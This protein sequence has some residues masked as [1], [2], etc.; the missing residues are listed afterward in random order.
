MDILIPI[1][2]IA[3]LILLNGLF[4][5]AEFAIIGAPRSAIE[6]RA[7]DGDPTARRVRDIQNDPR[8]QDRYIATAQLGIT[9]ASLG[10]GMYGEHTLAVWIASWL[11]GAAWAKWLLAHGLASGVAILFLTYLH[12]VLGE[13]V[14]KTFALSHAEQTVL[15]V[16]TP[17]LVVKRLLLPLVV[18]LN[19]TGNGLLALM[20]V[21]REFTKSHYH[22]PEELE[23]IIRE[24]EAGGLIHPETGRLLRELFD[25]GELTASE[26]AVPRVRMV[27]LP[28]NA[29]TDTIAATVRRAPHARYP[30]Y[31]R[32][33]DHIIGFV[34]VKVL[35]RL[36]GS[37]GTLEAQDVAPVAF[38]PES[39]PLADVLSAMHAVRSQLAIVMDEHGGTEGMISTEDLSAEII[40]ATEESSGRTRFWSREPDGRY[41]VT[42]TLR[43]EELAEILAVNVRHESVDTVSGLV[44]DLLG[45]PPKVGDRV[46]WRSAQ[47]EVTSVAGRGVGECLVALDS[48]STAPPPGA[49]S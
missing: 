28:I 39:A 19:S 17:M 2:I 35:L 38:V 27:A 21:R 33:R 20:G 48:K 6:R 25:F 22:S 13:M 47:F 36:L 45:R 10:L 15:Q 8:K 16:S 42:G 3:L 41:R 43:L 23:L 5:A 14:P 30:V 7:R 12:I 11:E 31:E 49:D 1:A 44:L 40:G 18:L 9:F 29:T 32:D 4:V 37:K 24:S 26:V 46:D 34:H